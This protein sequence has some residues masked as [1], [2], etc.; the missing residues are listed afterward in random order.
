[1]STNKEKIEEFAKKYI[2]PLHMSYSLPDP[3]KYFN[4]DSINDDGYFEQL[5]YI[6]LNGGD[7]LN[8]YDPSGQ[9]HVYKVHR[10]IAVHDFGDVK[11]G[12]LGGFVTNYD[13]MDPVLSLDNTCWI[14]K[15]GA[16]FDNAKIYE[17]AKV[18][19]KAWVYGKA[20]VSGYAIISHSAI[21]CDEAIVCD[22][23]IA[24]DR[25]IVCGRTRINGNSVISNWA[26]NS[27][28]CS[29]V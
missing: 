29:N 22:E 21:I 13:N 23:A 4:L 8:L 2:Y 24:R 25:A 16:V 7:L 14:Y 17:S 10:I 26:K 3:V 9:S 18:M 6:I 28:I 11:A 12:Q 19:D 15:D 20:R 5:K 1:M 27:R